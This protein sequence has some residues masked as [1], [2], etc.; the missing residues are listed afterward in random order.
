MRKLEQGDI[1]KTNFNPQ[2]GHEQAGYRPAVI[3]SCKLFNQA[4]QMPVICPI[5]N[6]KRRPFPFHISLD[7]RTKTTGIILCE[8]IKTFDIQ[9]RGYSFV[10]KLP[11]DLMKRVLNIIRQGFDFDE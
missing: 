6:G 7:D 8:Q 1:I 11:D 9:E 10:E 2:A 4:V 5:T 3:V